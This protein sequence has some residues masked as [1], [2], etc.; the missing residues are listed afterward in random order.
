MPNVETFHEDIVE[1]GADGTG[2]E[3]REEALIPSDSAAR[4]KFFLTE[5]NRDTFTFETGRLYQSDFGNPYLDFNDFSLKL[6]GFSLNVIR[7]VDSK[8]HELR[9][10][11][12]N[13]T[14]GEI[15]CVVLFTLLF[16][17]EFGEAE[18]EAGIGHDG[19]SSI[20]QEQSKEETA[21]RADYGNGDEPSP[22]EDDLD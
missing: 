20:A 21:S 2:E 16:G 19:R 15:Y 5:S 1:E 10:T 18:M 11:L 6:P 13:K 3:I 17:G 22:G 12:K 8:T 14:S 9:Y 4:K 7:Y